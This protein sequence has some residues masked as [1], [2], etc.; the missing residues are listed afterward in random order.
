VRTFP[1]RGLLAAAVAGL[2]AIGVPGLA[3]HAA[4]GGSGGSAGQLAASA[5]STAAAGGPG[6]AP[7][8]AGQLAALTARVDRLTA[9]AAA[10]A[11]RLEIASARTEGLRIAYGNL[12]FQQYRLQQRLDA[13]VRR[14]YENQGPDPLAALVVGLAPAEVQAAGLGEEQQTRVDAGL[15]RRIIGLTGAAGALRARLEA[16]RTELLGPALTAERA[17]SEATALLDT[18]RARYQA[19]QLAA[20]R[21]RLA[22]LSSQVTTGVSVPAGPAGNAA[23]A[24]QA[25]IVRLLEKAGARIPAGYRATSTVYDGI[26]SWYGPGFIG[27]PTASGAIYNPDLPTCAMLLVPLGTVVHV[28]NVDGGRATN[29]LV[30]D[31]GPYVHGRIIDMSPYGA[32]ALGFTGLATVTVTVLAPTH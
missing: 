3:A 31:R 24:S 11:H 15:L 26:A 1:R 4:S 5:A 2:L 29:C 9:V 25:A 17:V 16:Q 30:N 23:S 7:L 21:A 14:I 27:Q 6:G 12:L 10:A 32:A 20:E 19:E 8:T 18:A 28:V 22:A 13:Q